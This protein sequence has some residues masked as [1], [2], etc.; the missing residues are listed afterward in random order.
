MNPKPGDRPSVSK[1]FAFRGEGGS[2]F[3]AQSRFAVFG[4]QFRNS[5]SVPSRGSA[6][7]RGWRIVYVADSI[8]IV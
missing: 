3:C 2:A 6:T 8:G 7:L 4:I 5:Q 1:Q